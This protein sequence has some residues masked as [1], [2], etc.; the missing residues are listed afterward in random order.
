M[1]GAGF[2][3]RETS[4][5]ATPGV[6]PQLGVWRGAGV[7]EGHVGRWPILTVSMVVL[8]L[9]AGYTLGTAI[10]ARQL[11]LGLV[12]GALLAVGITLVVALLAVSPRIS[13]DLLAELAQREAY[14]A[15]VQS[16][17][18]L[19]ELLVH[20][21]R[22][23]TNRQLES[24]LAVQQR[25]GGRLGAILVRMGAITSSQLREALLGQR[26]EVGAAPE[27]AVSARDEWTAR[28]DR[29]EARP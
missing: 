21:H 8:S 4:Q 23:I 25:K 17:P 6:G 7:E 9:S 10:L 2:A 22:W 19:G 13:R 3:I 15:A 26:L 16:A 1:K 18:R 20:K 27:L 5:R 11:V 28:R 29:V 24:A 14:E 12:S